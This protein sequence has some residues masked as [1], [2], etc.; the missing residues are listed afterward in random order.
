MR[1]QMMYVGSSLTAYG[2]RLLCS[3]VNGKFPK[4]V[5]RFVM[6]FNVRSIARVILGSSDAV[7]FSAHDT[8]T[9]TTAVSDCDVLG[10]ACMSEHAESVKA[11]IIAAR[12]A[13]PSIFIVWG[14]VHAIMHPEDAIEYADAICLSEAETAFPKFLQKFKDHE[15]YTDT[16][17][18]WFRSG[19]QIIKNDFDSLLNSADLNK[20]PL[21][22]YGEGELIYEVGCDGFV[23]LSKSHYLKYDALSYH[24]VWSR[25]CPYRCTYCGNSR[26]LEIDPNFGK[27]RHSSVK[28]LI[29]EIRAATQKMPHIASITF[30]DDC[31]I[32]LPPDLLQ[33]FSTAMKCE[34]GLPFGIFGV[35]PADVR[36]EKIE[37]LLGGGLDRV[38]MGVQ[39]GSDKIL[40]FYKRP[41]RA[42]FVKQAVDTLGEFS[43]RMMPPWYDMIF[44][45]PIETT[46]DVIAT[47][48]LLNEM[49]RPFLLHIF[50][51]RYIPNTELGRQLASL[52]TEVEGIDKNYTHV[53]P[54]FAN[55]LM[56]CVYLVRVPSPIFEYLL[57]FAKPYR[58]SAH[59]YGHLISLLVILTMAKRLYYHLRWFDFSVVLGSLG[60]ALKRWGLLSWLQRYARPVLSRKNLV[61]LK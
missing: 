35:T 3:I 19:Q 6:F 18:F 32:G 31:F 36:K 48:R 45:N 51:L 7:E 26:F 15:D 55:V 57:K 37:I 30:H 29:S 39:S 1:I 27:L 47:L 20:L 44:D 41:N 24:T 54:I 13:N 8:K 5:C 34:V 25:G 40:K 58:E 9:I 53:K 52:N 21:P 42:G 28:H 10:I 33:E 56:Y 17:S 14:G 59:I 23:P 22:M 46:D 60:W 4:T 2:F 38:R 11:V 43:G 12:K 16:K 61:T 49:P 50:S